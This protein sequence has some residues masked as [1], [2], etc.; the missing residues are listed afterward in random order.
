MV[1]KMI[2]SLLSA[3]DVIFI[4]AVF[5]LQHGKLDGFYGLASD[6]ILYA[7]GDYGTVLISSKAKY[8]GMRKMLNL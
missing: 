6:N 5:S 3:N 8:N 1:V 7:C 4:S 2:V